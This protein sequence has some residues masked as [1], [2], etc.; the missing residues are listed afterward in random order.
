MHATVKDKINILF[1]S[2][3]MADGWQMNARYPNDKIQHPTQ[4]LHI[5]AFFGIQYS[6]CLE[7]KSMSS[8]RNRLIYIFH[9]IWLICNASHISHV[10]LHIKY[11]PADKIAWKRANEQSNF[12]DFLVSLL[13]YFSKVLLF[14]QSSIHWVGECLAGSSAGV[15]DMMVIWCGVHII[16]FP[17]NHNI[18]P[19][20]PLTLLLYFHP[21]TD[22]HKHAISSADPY[23]D[24]GIRMHSVC[25]FECVRALNENWKYIVTLCRVLWRWNEMLTPANV[26][27]CG[28]HKQSNASDIS[29]LF[30][31]IQAIL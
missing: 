23:H 28:P 21:Q 19:K 4:F 7:W 17:H 26:W 29:F 3:G 9:S 6:W 25:V 24:N 14:S 2:N 10:L 27:M 15:D 18:L 30:K 16:S 5:T 8:H 22:S 11:A 13:L 1:V 31:Y 12:N 20:V